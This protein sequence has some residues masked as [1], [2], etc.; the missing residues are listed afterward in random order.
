MSKQE[1]EAPWPVPPIDEPSPTGTAL[2]HYDRET[3]QIPNEAVAY[4]RILARLDRPRARPRRLVAIGATAVAIP[5]ML[6]MLWH[7]APPAVVPEPVLANKFA[8]PVASP[9]TA[10]EEASTLSFHVAVVSTPLP[11]GELRLEGGI[12]AVLAEDTTA[13]ARLEQGTLDI[14]LAGGSIEL[15]IPPRAVGQAV[16]V[17]AGDLHFMA[18]G[19]VF[20]LSYRARHLDLE[21]SDGLVTVS[22]D[23]DHLATVAA[24]ENWAANQ[25]TANPRREDALLARHIPGR[26]CAGIGQAQ[27]QLACYRKKARRNGA[28][29][30]Q[31]QYALARL[32]RDSLG[33]L[34]GALRAFEEQRSRFPRGKLEVEADRAIIDLL[35]RLGRYP[36]ALAETQLL[37]DAHPEANYRAEIRLVRGDIYRALMRDPTS[38]EREYGGGAK[39]E[40]R[41]G[42]DSR[43]LRALCLEAL[44]RMDEARLAYQEYLAQAGAAH[45]REAKRRMERLSP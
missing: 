29:G 18:V 33:D 26:E 23:G 42:D 34:T 39:A 35:V 36:E 14:A 3:A 8:S 9:A 38:A 43:F 13:T 45:A 20:T 40:G 19:A 1:P 10:I 4:A 5:T 2:R 12:T 6:W 21:V 32:L 41:A 27:E 44:G 25:P 17:A 31:A 30:E 24:R 11:V 37:L 16:L 15:H 7:R 28:A 22:R